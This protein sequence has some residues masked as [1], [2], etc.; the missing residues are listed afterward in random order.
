MQDTDPIKRPGA[1]RDGYNSLKNHPF[2]QGIDW[3]NIRSR[4]PPKLVFEKVF[5]N[6]FF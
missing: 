4:N 2:F 3:H 6:Y 1:G 5:L